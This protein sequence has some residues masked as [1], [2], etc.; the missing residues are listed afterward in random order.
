[1][2]ILKHYKYFKNWTGVSK[3]MK[4]PIMWS[5]ISIGKNR[6]IAKQR[7]STIEKNILLSYL[8]ILQFQ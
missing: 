8:K 4:K 3:T 2:R 6:Q 7:T 1:M 5:I